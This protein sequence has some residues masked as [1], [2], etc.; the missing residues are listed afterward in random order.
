M[1]IASGN[2]TT[3]EYFLSELNC[4]RDRAARFGR[5]N[6]RV[7]EELQLGNGRSDDPHVELLLQSFAYLT[8]RLRYDLDAEL[9]EVSN[10]LLRYLYPHLEAPTPPM[11]IVELEL[12][13]NGADY[14]NGYAVSKGKLLRR[15]VN[16]SDNKDYDCLFS[17][18][19]DA[20]LWPVKI[21]DM[22]VVPANELEFIR[23]ERYRHCRSALRV[24][25]SSLKEGTPLSA[26]MTSLRFWVDAGRTDSQ[27]F[28]ELTRDLLG[29][30]AVSRSGDQ[31]IEKRSLD[32]AW[33]GFE[34]AHAVLPYRKNSHRAFR[35]L[36]EYFW[37]PEKYLFFNLNGIQVAEGDTTLDIV[38]MFDRDI[39]Q[40]RDVNEGRLRI[41][42]VPAINLYSTATDPIGPDE[43]YFE[44]LLVP[45]V[46][47]YRGLEVHSVDKVVATDVQG[48]SRTLAPFL[49]Q[50]NIGPAEAEDCYW[51]I[52]RDYTEQF[53]LP[54][55]QTWLALHDRGGTPQLLP[56]DSIH[57]EVRV[58]NRDIAENMHV[59]TELRVVGE[60]P[61]ARA[62][63]VTKPS[64]HRTPD[65]RGR[66]PWL[67]ISQLSLNFTALSGREANVDDL[68]NL[69]R[70][71]ADEQNLEQQRLIDALCGISTTPSVR[72]IG[73]DA[74]RGFCS[75]ITVTITIDEKR[76]GVASLKLFGDVLSRFLALY[77]SVNSFVTLKM[78]SKQTLR[79]LEE[80]PPMVGEKVLL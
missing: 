68:K 25:I 47:N 58:T 56:N 31:Y 32:M 70:L 67:L 45:D 13:P 53:H 64:R 2:A 79:L 9:P 51:S 69:L 12:Y 21:D 40:I 14:D 6:P 63:L 55:T 24:S 11:A 35:L 77:A 39:T 61:F 16:A 10:N 18:A 41:N 33:W 59:G 46:Q 66:K 72:H 28:Y 65:V 80:W 34:D 4:L 5:E 15:T 48:R 20:Q 7:A 76:L 60:G 52:R 75:G 1:A 37:F 3:V 74:W 71:Y 42:C 57:A 30:V 27:A 50:E 73:P 38:F 8:G 62:T 26:S 29:A 54:G 17:I 44:N 23:C 43:R 49:P 19:A 78:Q 22:S 36:Q